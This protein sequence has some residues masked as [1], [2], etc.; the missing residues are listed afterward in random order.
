MKW[1][2][3]DTST[4][5]LIVILGEDDKCV[6]Q[7]EVKKPFEHARDLIPAIQKCLQ[8]KQWKLEDLEWVTAGAGPGSYTG[9]RIGLSALKA[10]LAIVSVKVTLFSSLGAIAWQLH[11]KEGIGWVLVDARRK[12]V[13]GQKVI[14][15]GGNVDISS[16]PELLTPEEAVAK[17]RSEKGQVY[18]AG[19]AVHRLESLYQQLQDTG[20]ILPEILA[21][22]N[23]QGVFE[24]AKI[25]I[26]NGK[27]FSSQDIKPMYMRLSEAEETHAR[28]NR[29]E[30]KRHS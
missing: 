16:A 30:N 23:A 7:E 6:A 9:L 17:I 11:D 14:I 24:A 3:F 21:Y 19:D 25:A 29:N 26:Q 18:I 10:L 4:P 8:K 1:L 12:M 2:A 13:Y 20:E 28:I 22:P 15:Q 27:T 5:L